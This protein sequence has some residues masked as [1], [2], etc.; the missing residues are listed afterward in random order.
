MS[1]EANHQ[2]PAF[3]RY[4]NRELGTSEKSLMQLQGGINNRVFRCGE[5]PNQWVIK[6][7]SPI[8]LDQRDRMQAEVDFLRYSAQVA[9]GFTP[10][11]IHTDPDRRCV[12]LEYIKGTPFSEGNEPPQQAIDDA[13]NFIQLLN[14]DPKAGKQ[15]ILIEAAD[16][17]LSLS[18]HLQNLKERLGMLECDHLHA[19]AKPKAVQLIS[20]LRNQLDHTKNLTN[21]LIDQGFISDS[22][23]PEDRWISPSDFGFHNSLLT[24]HG[25]KFIDFEFSGWDDPLKTAADFA[26]QPQVPI[27]SNESPLLSLIVYKDKQRVFKRY[28]CMYKIMFLKWITIMLGF[29]NPLRLSKILEIYRSSDKILLFDQQLQ[30]VEKYLFIHK[31][32]WTG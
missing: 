28:S 1:L 25:V 21:Q 6:G 32:F 29:L 26:L 11:L 5:E 23:M 31:G 2:T 9:P 4:W 14:A 7:Y 10:K 8:E 18:D 24:V 20:Q 15:G 3:A 27:I 30:R 13:V 17:F 22:I 19:T 12:V 16:G